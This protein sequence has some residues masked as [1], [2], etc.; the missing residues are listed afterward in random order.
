MPLPRRRSLDTFPVELKGEHYFVLRDTEGV[1]DDPMIL[2]PFSF[3]VW[4]LLT[5]ESTIEDLKREIANYADGVEI[6]DTRL[7]SIVDRLQK[8]LLV[9][10]PEV[11]ERRRRIA[12]QF[13]EAPTRPARFAGRGGYPSE[14][15]ALTKEIDGHY[16]NELGA[17]APDRAKRGPGFRGILSPHI[18]FRRGGTC[19]THA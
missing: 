11:D 12:E 5:G 13:Q 10:S 16:K 14:P 17:G 8:S 3:L 4:N 19:Y 18:D 1:L 6:P 2:D 7:Q 15:D 9:E